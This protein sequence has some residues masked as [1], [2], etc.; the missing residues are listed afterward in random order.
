MINIIQN[1]EPLFYQVD[2][3]YMQP[4]VTGA[5]QWNGNTKQFEVSNGISWMAINGNV[6]LNTSADIVEML[7]W[8]KHKMQEEKELAT[9]AATSPTVADLVNTISDARSKI[10]IVKTLINA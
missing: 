7:A 8:A 1:A 5:V 10:A 2:R 3:G 4:H 9:L 6:E